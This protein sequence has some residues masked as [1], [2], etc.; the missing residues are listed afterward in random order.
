MAI[1]T[2]FKNG[3][4]S[5]ADHPGVFQESKSDLWARV[6]TIQLME[7]PPPSVP[8][9]GTIGSRSASWDALFP[10]QNSA[11]LLSGSRFFGNR[12]GWTTSAMF[13][14]FMPCSMTR[15]DSFGSASA[16]R[17][18]ITQPAVPPKMLCEYESEVNYGKFKE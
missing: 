4:R 1:H 18:A 15:I 8:P 11:V 2:F 14:L 9:D 12:A 3:H 13:Q 6:Y 17:E 10:F 7:E 16:N 5:L